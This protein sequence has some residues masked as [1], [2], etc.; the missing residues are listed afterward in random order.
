MLFGGVI[1]MALALMVLYV[2]AARGSIG[3]WGTRSLAEP[4]DTSAD[5]VVVDR[6]E[7]DLGTVPLDKVVPVAVHLANRSQRTIQLA[8]ATAET[9]EG[10]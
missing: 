6:Q 2:V 4:V 10:C 8:Q 1:G 9:L 5:A 7:I 3:A